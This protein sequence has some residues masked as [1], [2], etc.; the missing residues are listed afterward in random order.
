MAY[1][2]NQMKPKKTVS[3]EKKIKKN[4]VLSENAMKKLKDHAK[5]HKGGMA[6]KHM[7]TMIKK[8][9]DGF[10]FSQ[11]HKIALAN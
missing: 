1:G 8:M 11:A 7:K 5:L 9:K 4:I 3:F 2:S 6:S 10:S